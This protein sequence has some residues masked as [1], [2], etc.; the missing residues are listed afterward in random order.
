MI[1]IRS[2]IN[3]SLSRKLLYSS[4][5]FILGVILGL[6]SKML[7]TP[8]SISLPYFLEIFDLRNFFSRMGVWIFLAVVI[9]MYSKSP[10]RSAL[11][12]FLF[13]AGMVGSYF[14]YTVLV[15]GF[16]PK[17]YMMIWIVMTVISPFLAFV[18]WYAK[19]KGII[20]ISISTIIFM[21]ISRQTFAFGFWYF[22]I[23][24]ILEFLLWIATIFV[25]YQS[26]KQIIKVLSIGLLLF[27]LTAQTNLFWG[28]L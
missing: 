27:F 9:S 23:M 17:S 19:G 7:E 16:F 5:I 13:F 6:F 21:F 1:L 10:I 11:N 22:D 15:A 3:I 14:L 8:Q 2:P 18:C 28:M 25:L 24:N 4:L 26:P 12:V 20:A